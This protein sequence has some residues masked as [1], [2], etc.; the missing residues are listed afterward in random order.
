M[1]KKPEI[2]LRKRSQKCSQIVK[3]FCSLLG[4]FKFKLRLVLRGRQLWAKLFKRFKMVF[5][6]SK[7]GWMDEWNGMK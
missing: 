7:E 5:M 6:A 4:I 1:K 2:C 3:R